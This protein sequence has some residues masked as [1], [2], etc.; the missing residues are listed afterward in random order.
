MVF[1]IFYLGTENKKKKRNSSIKDKKVTYNKETNT[2]NIDIII[3]FL[4]NISKG[5]IKQKKLFKKILKSQLNTNLRSIVWRISLDILPIDSFKEWEQ[6]SNNNRRLFYEKLDKNITDELLKYLLEKIK[7]DEL[8]YILK[9]KITFTNSKCPFRS[10]LSVYSDND[11]STNENSLENEDEI[12]KF[13]E[14]I[15]TIKIDIER[16][17]QEIELFKQEN[18][19]II[20]FTVLV[21]YCLESK[22]GY[23]QGMNEI[24]GT[25]LLAIQDTYFNF[26]EID[27]K[28]QES[29]DENFIAF[30]LHDSL[31]ISADLYYIFKAVMEN[32]GLQGLYN[33]IIGNEKL[34]ASI[35][36]K[37]LSGITIDDIQLSECSLLKKKINKIFYCY[38]K[39]ADKELFQHIFE[40]VEPYIFMFRWILCMLNREIKIND[41]ILLWDYIFLFDLI[42][43]S[44]IKEN[45]CNYSFLDNLN[46]LDFLIISMIS[47]I[48]KKLLESDEGF[49]ILDALMHFPTDIN[50]NKLLQTAL[51]VR[52]KIYNYLKVNKDI[53]NIIE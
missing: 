31:H 40:K 7:K 10:R 29:K 22:T 8:L 17:F 9:Q 2:F 41:C 46:F 47:Q 14:E 13:V 43:S 23:C 26:P 11:N 33:Y 36:N 49:I 42:E 15:R 37:D 4:K 20:L 3:K 44:V 6:I 53:I 51:K 48:K 5:K 18:I 28:S 19:K 50:I 32:K 38:L 24:A 12:I 25:I 16:T 52:N 21:I 34:N 27:I 1:I 39:I 45:N 30:I 35:F